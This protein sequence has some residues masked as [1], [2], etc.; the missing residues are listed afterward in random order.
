MTELF[1]AEVFV[2][3]VLFSSL[4]IFLCKAPSCHA[5]WRVWLHRHCYFPI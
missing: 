4:S 2:I 5:S 3:Y 1:S